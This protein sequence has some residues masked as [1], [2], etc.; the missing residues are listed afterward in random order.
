MDADLTL[1]VVIVNFRTGNLVVDCL[2]SLM[3]PGTVPQGTRIV[4]VDASSGDRSIDQITAA[5]DGCG[6]SDRV[7]LL[8]L[9][10]NA[11]FAYGNNRGIEYARRRFGKPSY[12]LLLN[13]DTIVRP[14]AILPLVTFMDEHPNAGISG[15][16]L[17]DPDGTPQACAFR[18]PSI[19]AEFESEIRFGLVTR[20][21]RRWRIAPDMPDIPSPIHW[22]SGAC[23]IL[24]R[25]LLEQIGGLDEE[26]FLYYEEVD[27]CLRAAQAKWECWHVPESRVVHLVGQA[28]GVTLRHIR[29]PRRPSYWFESRRRYF[30]KHHG[31]L[32]TVVADLAWVVGHV[33]FAMRLKLQGRP[34]S[35]PPNLLRDFV[36]HANPLR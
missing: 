15:S 11:G 23:M 14:G 12:I 7:S 16:R 18:F 32:Y 1:A 25:E 4:V 19:A 31:I 13:P 17:E 3:V 2:A 30:L 28:T 8:P 35:G 34:A 9:D 29:P 33:C 6:W 10:I 36:R 22:V 26:Y 27:F 21:L 5:I 20:L 24:R